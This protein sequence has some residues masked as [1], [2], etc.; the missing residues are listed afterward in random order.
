MDLLPKVDDQTGA[1]SAKTFDE[2]YENNDEALFQ[3]KMELS[4]DTVLKFA[5]YS[6]KSMEKVNTH[7]DTFLNDWKAAKGLCLDTDDR[8]SQEKEKI[9]KS[10][11][12][13]IY[14]T[15]NELTKVTIMYENMMEKNKELSNELQLLK[16]VEKEFIEFKQK[17]AGDAYKYS[18]MEIK[19]TDLQEDLIE[20]GVIINRQQEEISKLQAQYQEQAMVIVKDVAQIQHL[21]SQIDRF[22]AEVGKLTDENDAIQVSRLYFFVNYCFS[23]QI[24]P[25]IIQL[26]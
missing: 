17:A 7:L 20:K 2:F 6:A 15:A 12:K 11:E 22:Q 14:L 16:Q 4:T 10:F 3:E 9:R 25:K 1:R 5:D 24:L 26:Q 23:L 18:L 13:Q 19:A 8:I 21:Q